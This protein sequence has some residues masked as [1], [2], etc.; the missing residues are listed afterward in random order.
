M[1]SD[2]PSKDSDEIKSN[3]EE[4]N[5]N[6]NNLNINDENE[7]NVQ[8]NYGNEENIINIEQDATEGR[9]SLDNNS[10]EHAITEDNIGNEETD[11]NAENNNIRNEEISTNVEFSP[12]DFVQELTNDVIENARSETFFAA[13]EEATSEVVET[14]LDTATSEVIIEQSADEVI[15]SILDNAGDEIIIE[16]IDEEDSFGENDEGDGGGDGTHVSERELS[17]I[18]A[19]AYLTTSTDFQPNLYDHLTNVLKKLFDERPENPIEIFENISRQVKAEQFTSDKDRIIDEYVPSLQYH[20]AQEQKS[21]FSKVSEQEQEME[22][23][24]EVDTPLPDI[25][26]LSFNFEQAGVGLGREETY[27]IFLALNQLVESHPLQT[28][29]FWGKILGTKSN[30]IIG[31]VQYREGEDV[32]EE[33]EENEKSDDKIEAGEE[34]EEAQGEKEEDDF[35]KSTYKPPPVIPKEENRFGTN[36]FSYFVCSQPGKEW[37][38]LPPVTPDQISISRKIKKIFTGNLDAPIVS[39]P[40]FPGNEANYLRAMIARISAGTQISPFSYYHFGEEEE[41]EDED[42]FARMDFVK[43]S[44]FGGY[45]PRE[46][47]DPSKWVHHIQ[48]I[49]PQGRCKW[50]NSVQRD[51]NIEED[52]ED[53]E[54]EEEREIA[55]EPVPEAGPMLLTPLSED[56]SIDSTPPWSFALSS[57]LI[58]QYALAVVKSNLWPGATTFSNGMKFENVYIG[59][60]HKYNSQNYSPA[61]PPEVQT[62]YPSGPEITEAADPAVEEEAALRAVQEERMAAA[63]EMEEMEDDED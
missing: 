61:P 34:E 4:N 52:E 23:D 56:V 59:F 38:K 39:Y 63:E 5:D 7:E 8:I 25:M 60:G 46:L 26:E 44:D 10:L 9:V 62:E 28:V 40:P 18:N 54:E 16:G 20:L 15:N 21:L 41:E 42:G 36:K 32:E 17:I 49:L 51:N 14:I 45:T 13:L 50:F 43:N 31:E 55:D 37:I 6:E 48:Y 22:T 53:D 19:K 3:A 47:L 11:V 27:K 58:P 12:D 35:P 30:Y 33:E 57:N 24:E 1:N 29:R 2:D